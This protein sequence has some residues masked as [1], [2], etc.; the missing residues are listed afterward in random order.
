MFRD[1]GDS[2]LSEQRFQRYRGLQRRQLHC[3]IRRRVCCQQSAFDTDTRRQWR[4]PEWC[5]SELHRAGTVRQT[6]CSIK[7]VPQVVSGAGPT[8]ASI[9]NAVTV[10]DQITYVVRV[11][12]VSGRD[13]RIG[14]CWATDDVSQIDLADD[15]GCS[16]QVCRERQHCDH[17]N[18]HRQQ[19][20]CG[21]ISV[22]TPNRVQMM[23]SSTQPSKHGHFQQ[24]IV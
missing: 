5:R 4:R 14:K 23:S 11:S 24:V 9:V 12:A 21:R 17:S 13:V 15:K 19:I 1:R 7:C 6:V 22:A 8:G 20:L 16:V 10:G 18:N 2:E 3:Q